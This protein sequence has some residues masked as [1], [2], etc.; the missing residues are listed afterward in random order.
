[1]ILK[2]N[3]KFSGKIEELDEQGYC[4]LKNH[5]D[6]SLID[7][8]REAFLPTFNA[9]VSHNGHLPNRGVSRYFLPM[10]FEQPCFASE[11]FFDPQILAILKN[12]MG[13]RIVADQWGCDVPLL[14][15]TYQ[16]VHVDY[17]RPLFY[18][19]PDLKLPAYMMVVSF[20]L[21]TITVENGATEFAPGTH[22]MQR[23]E[24]F[25]G[26]EKSKIEMLP[27]TMDIGDVL[28]RHPWILH[29]GT[30][31]KTTTPRLLVTIRYVRS[32][33]CDDSREINS[34]PIT[35]WNSLSSEQKSMLRFPVTKDRSFKS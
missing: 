16:A 34:I 28:I 9:Y 20:G 14:G 4:I 22:K 8:C 3:G 5:F 10:P 2:P 17:Q 6:P 29:R 18:E 24:A 23:E 13:D 15:S 19:M 32:W 27:V 33:Y 26:V 12:T 31:N 11:F 25:N 1:M 21:T 30:P 7:N 35:V